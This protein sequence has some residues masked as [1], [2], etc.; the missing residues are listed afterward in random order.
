MRLYCIYDRVAQESGPIYEAKNDAVALRMT[1]QYI[2]EHGDEYYV[3][4]LGD[5]YHDPVK[6]VSLDVPLR[7]V[8]A[9]EFVEDNQVDETAEFGV[10]GGVK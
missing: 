8:S 7:V 6:L 9:P 3:L 1:Q 5:Y 10:T 4:Y 2:A